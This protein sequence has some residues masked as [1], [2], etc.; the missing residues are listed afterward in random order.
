MKEKHAKDNVYNRVLKEYKDSK[1]E[2]KLRS[3]SN[4]SMYEKIKLDHDDPFSEGIQAKVRR[5]LGETD[6]YQ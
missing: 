4:I 2:Q 5:D 1:I 3:V 6:R